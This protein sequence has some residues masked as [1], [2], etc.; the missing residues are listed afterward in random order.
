M[1]RIPFLVRWPGKV[2]AGQV[3]DV[4]QSTVDLAPTFL[5]AAGLPI[6]GMMQGYDELPAWCG[7]DAPPLAEPVAQGVH[8]GPRDHVIVENR[9]QPTK[10]H[11]R[12]YVDTR[13]K[14]TVYRN[15]DYG[16]LFDL[17]EDP[18]EVHNLWHDPRAAALKATLLHRAVQYEIQREPTR[19]P[20]VAGA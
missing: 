18:D 5:T 11:L 15:H 17:E 20:R 9:H 8:V 19:M 1:I 6:P 10:L 4:L 3:S 16:E 7:D 13:Y 14:L 2:P 12:T